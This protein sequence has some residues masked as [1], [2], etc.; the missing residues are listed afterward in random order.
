MKTVNNQLAGTLVAVPESR[1]LDT[2]AELLE[3]RGAQVLRVPLVAIH[4]AP[5]SAPVL[6]WIH[7]FCE[8]PPDLFI[9]LTGEGIRRLLSLAAR[10]GLQEQLVSALGRTTTLC[11]GPKPERALREVGLK[12]SL[13]ASAPT[14][15]GVIKTLEN[16][17]V[18]GQR[19]A[20]Q[21]YGDDPNTR[22]M[23]YLATR[24]LQV[25]TVAPYIYADD[26]DDARVIDLIR[27]LDKEAV[28]VLAFTSKPQVKRLFQMAQRHDLEEVLRF[29]MARCCIAAVGPVV[30]D[31]L[32]EQGVRVD[33]MPSQAFF[34]KPLVT[35]IMR[36][37]GRK[38]VAEAEP[39]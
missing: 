15:E 23:D 32:E 21:L 13:Q 38:P 6:G 14:T 16:M 20:V 24:Q 28:D 12:G 8:N 30:R 17:P 27:L 34:M 19:I 33:I 25:S 18:E 31:T 37:A 5:D 1:Q 2:M 26:S 9:I 39:G 4:D 35:E 11:R 10:H 22:L 3:R 36:R 29:G 7:A